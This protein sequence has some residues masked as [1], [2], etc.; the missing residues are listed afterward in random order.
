MAPIEKRNCGLCKKNINFRLSKVVKCDGD[1]KNTY[2]ITCAD[3]NDAKYDEIKNDVSQFWLCKTCKDKKII[4]RASFYGNAPSTPTILTP[5]INV[6]KINDSVTL[7]SLNSKINQILQ[8][9]D[10]Y[11]REL[12][13]L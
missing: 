8:R 7:E 2:H 4:Q 10:E 12:N 13:Q 11:F 1:C 6:P 5:T 9:Q 3:V